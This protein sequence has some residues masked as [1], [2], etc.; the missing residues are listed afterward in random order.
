MAAIVLSLPIL[1]YLTIYNSA[2]ATQIMWRYGYSALTLFF[3][4]LVVVALTVSPVRAIFSFPPL[5]WTGILCYPL[6]LFHVPYSPIFDKF[7]L[8]SLYPVLGSILAT[9]W[10][11]YVVKIGLLFGI[12]TALHYAIERPFIGLGYRLT[13]A[14]RQREHI[15]MSDRTLTDRRSEPT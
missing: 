3:G 9:A 15:S 10:A 11:V 6:Y 1:S 12:A 4:G 13:A 8:P 7:I 5:R 14:P 2:P